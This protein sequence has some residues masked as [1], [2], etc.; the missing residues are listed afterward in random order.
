MPQSSNERPSR[1]TGA[2]R[3]EP[4]R[5]AP[6][7]GASAAGARRAPNDAPRPRRRRRRRHMNPL[8]YIMLILAVSALLAGLGW[9]WACD[10][11]AL[12]KPANS[13]VI[14][15]SPD[16]FT[17]REVESEVT[18][19]GVTETVTKTIQVADL[20][21]VTELLAENGLIEYKP[22]FKLFCTFSGVEKKGKLLPG[23]YE[24]NTDMDYHALVNAMSSGSSNRMT[25]TV[26]IPE[27]YNIDQI[28]ALLEEKGVSTVETLQKV[29]ATYDYKF[30]FLKDVRPFG[31]YSL[32]D[33]HRLEGYLFPDTYEFYMGGGEKAAV[34]VLNKM[35]VR[36]SQLFTDDMRAQAEEMG[37]SFH[38]ILTIASLIEKE[39][40]GE[41]Q[42][43]IASV[44]Y[45]RLERPTD[46]TVGLLQIDATLV[47]ALGR[48]ITQED[49]TAS[50][51]YNTYTNK[52]LPPTP[53]AN[54]GL[55][56]LNAALN[57]ANTKYYYYVLGN[58]G[59]HHFF[60]THQEHQSFIA[61][62]K[63]ERE[64]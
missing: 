53:I 27:G 31:D 16:I 22:L 40:D 14:T 59:Q 25:V 19:D 41:D 42:D 46:E 5:R 49:Y 37:Y 50:T 17:S 29:A 43:K 30:S 32:G 7:G 12:N 60:R 1:A 54:P 35:M 56:A 33:Y 23:T 8:L 18:T 10:I 62:Q 13:A 36:L 2:S 48:S 15:L 11:L 63:A 9:T 20:D 57:P 45:N 58:D 52:G 39:T 34:Q 6:S 4:P 51:D 3:S 26:T 21:Y 47:Y 61:Q 64:Q 24:L 38:E 28:F 55:V 44:I